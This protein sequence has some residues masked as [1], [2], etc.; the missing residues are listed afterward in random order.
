[1]VT[2][3]NNIYFILFYFNAFSTQN[4]HIKMSMKATVTMMIIV[5]M[6]QGLWARVTYSPKTNYL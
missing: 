2:E 1:M 6:C 5:F 3:I 4:I